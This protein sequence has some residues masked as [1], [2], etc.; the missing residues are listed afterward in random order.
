MEEEMLRVN[1]KS[2]YK[3]AAGS[4]LGDRGKKRE[5]LALSGPTAIWT[6]SEIQS[7]ARR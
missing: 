4:R 5:A 1:R 7:Q 3:K 6:Q 2:S